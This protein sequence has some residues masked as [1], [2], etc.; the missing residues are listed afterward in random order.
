MP[1]V[2][3]RPKDLFGN[4]ANVKKLLINNTA[5]KS[6]TVPW[7]VVSDRDNNHVY[8][9]ASTGS[10]IV[11]DVQFREL[12]YVV[13]EKEDWIKIA[14]A[15]NVNKLKSSSIETIGWIEKSKMLL[16]T[17]G[18][19]DQKTSINRKAFLLN[20]ADD[21][22]NV[23]KRKLDYKEL[24]VDIYR[25]PTAQK[26]EIER[27]IYDYYFVFKKENNMFLLAEEAS[28]TSYNL[29]SKLIGWV[30]A[31]RTQDWNTRICL[32]PNFEEAAFSERKVNPK[33][34]FKAFG[35]SSQVKEYVLSGDETGVFWDSDPVKFKSAEMAKSDPKRFKGNVVRFPMF[36]KGNFGDAGFFK[37]GVIG[38]IKV[39]N[40]EGGKLKFESEIP[41]MQIADIK[42][43]LADLEYK[44]NNVN[45]FFIIEGTDNSYAFQRDIAEAIR[46]TS[47]IEQLKKSTNVNYGALIYR[48]VPEGERIIEYEKLTPNLN[49]VVE[50]VGQADFSNKV[51]QDDF[52]AFYYGLKQGLKVAG[53]DKKAVNIIVLVGSSGDYS[54]DKIR[55]QD[56][57]A[58][59]QVSLV[60][61]KGPI[62]QSLSDLNA[63]LYSIQL[64]NDGRLRT[65]IAY[66]IQSHRMILESARYIYNKTAGSSFTRKFLD[67]YDEQDGVVFTEP[68]MEEPIQVTTVK[69]AGT[70]PGSILLPLGKQSLKGEQLQAGLT[71]MISGSLNYE[72]VV[73][74]IFTAAYSYNK[75][76]IRKISEENG[77]AIADLTSGVIQVLEGVVKESGVDEDVI[78]KSTGL[79]LSLYTEVYL[80]EKAKDAIHPMYSYVV[81][82][83]EADLLRYQSLI[84][85]NMGVIAQSGSYPDKRKSLFEIYMA[86][87]QQFAGQDYLKGK[88]PEDF[89]RGDVLSI[90]Q[91]LRL[92]GFKMNVELN[93][94]VGDIRN[95]K[96]VTDAEIDALIQRF[97]DVNDE[98]NKI[99]KLNDRF[100]FCLV[101]DNANRYYWLR[102]DQVF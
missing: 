52:T 73:K 61:D 13:D 85:R 79:K 3:T 30:D 29:N 75:L 69:M 55:K 44:V 98:L 46:S 67:R 91:G 62:F 34:Q 60:Q 2:M 8:K 90:M 41:E 99:I 94:R 17:S 48:D 54:V 40:D 12:F 65:G 28:L 31:R 80:P 78:I 11:K 32:E 63:H 39:L 92:E 89:T 70:R 16:W 43:V 49:K 22:S 100:D 15:T 9:E 47:Q 57:I 37:S 45:L 42:E 64:Y 81:F 38:S 97:S 5:N 6:K 53:F 14:T 36:S 88:N 77:I 4:P 19:L 72:K 24:I 26:K 27:T 82:M 68:S 102:L 93:V 95:E 1:E 101:S 76:D 56:A 83:P 20:R 66:G 87:I 51:D 71:E 84:N 25:D 21:V 35:K 86:L 33:Q 23:L 50:F 74:D 96:K 58:K 59:E 18:L 7:I 10:S